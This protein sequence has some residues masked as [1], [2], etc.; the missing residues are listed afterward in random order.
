MM[1]W[2]VIL[3]QREGAAVAVVVQA[4]ASHVSRWGPLTLLNGQ[5][6]RTSDS[7][8][9]NNDNINIYLLWPVRDKSIVVEIESVQ[10]YDV[11]SV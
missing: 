9:W 3:E 7:G 11:H 5:S 8:S 4:Y 1:I 6:P 2:L 10:K